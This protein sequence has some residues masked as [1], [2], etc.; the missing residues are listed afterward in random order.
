MA[1]RDE[2]L[3]HALEL[4]APLGDVTA[5]RMFGGHGI[6]CGG[7]FFGIL[8]DNTLYLKADDRNRYEFERAGSEIFSYTRKGKRATLNFYRAPEE[9]MDTPHLMLPWAR[10]ALAAALRVRAGTQPSR[11]PRP[12]KKIRPA[13]S[14]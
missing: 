14:R 4:L 5:R 8:L 9:A 2:F 12:V 7:V 11:K 3:A 13:G 10:S 6:Y 1:G